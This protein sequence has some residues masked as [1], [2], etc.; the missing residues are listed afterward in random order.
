MFDRF[1]N[2]PQSLLSR[3]WEIVQLLFIK[4]HYFPD[5]GPYYMETILLICRA[6]KRT[7]F[8]IIG[9]SIMKE[10]TYSDSVN[11]KLSPSLEA[12]FPSCSVKKVFWKML[13]LFTE[14]HLC[15]GLLLLKLQAWRLVSYKI[16]KNTYFEKLLRTFAST[17]LNASFLGLLK[18][19]LVR[20][21]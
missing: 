2:M 1:L 6:N 7:G 11:L 13:L 5:G 16:F 9:T 8:S 17:T 20:L 18:Q 12:V 4:Y 10:L 19:D 3:V 14:K 21:S 15:W